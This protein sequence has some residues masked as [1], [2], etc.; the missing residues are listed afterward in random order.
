MR[1][2]SLLTQSAQVDWYG[3]EF[4]YGKSAGTRI[5]NMSY[6]KS[7]PLQSQL[8]RCIINTNNNNVQFIDENNYTKLE[9]GSDALYDFMG[10]NVMVYIPK[11]Y[12]SATTDPDTKKYTV[13][14]SA[15]QQD[16][17]IESQECYVAAFEGY[18]DGS[19][20]MSWSGKKP[21]TGRD[22]SISACQNNGKG[23]WCYTYEIHKAICFLF[24]VEYATL[25]SQDGFIPTITAEGYHQGGLGMGVTATY[26][27]LSTGNTTTYVNQTVGSNSGCIS[28]R[29]I[30]N[31]FGNVD[32]YCNLMKI[33]NVYYRVTYP[34]Q[35]LEQIDIR[36]SDEDGVITQVLD[37]EILPVETKIVADAFNDELSRSLSSQASIVLGGNCEDTYS[38][39]L[40]RIK[41]IQTVDDNTGIRLTYYPQ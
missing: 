9:N 31:P 39:G 19:A 18:L 21:T 13:K 10:M 14:I 2:R 25:D 17:F 35:Q 1:R 27:V 22:I 12:Y 20:V 15:N 30:E 32:K 7:L 29:G 24:I 23:W 16:G 3:V 33:N 36:M 37:N 11:F 28:Y 38:A 26:T 5:G 34:N 4:E 40:F 8:R 6:H 41:E